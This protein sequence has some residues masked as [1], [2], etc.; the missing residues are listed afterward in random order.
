VET[1]AAGIAFPEANSDFWQS[2][3]TAEEEPEP[4]A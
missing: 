3:T 2:L 4:A 1:I